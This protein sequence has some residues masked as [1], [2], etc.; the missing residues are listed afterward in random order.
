M[1]MN[2]ILALEP[3]GTAAIQP[4]RRG[5]EDRGL[6]RQSL[7]WLLILFGLTMADYLT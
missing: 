7:Y 4:A 2:A 5:I 1:T 6:R 3:A